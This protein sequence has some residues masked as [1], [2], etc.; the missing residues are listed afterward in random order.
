MH[1]K[2]LLLAEVMA[3]SRLDHLPLAD[4]VHF[5]VSVKAQIV[6]V[7]KD[8]FEAVI[9]SLANAS[10]NAANASNAPAPTNANTRLPSTSSETVSVH[11]STALSSATQEHRYRRIPPTTIVGNGITSLSVA[12]GDP[13]VPCAPT[14]FNT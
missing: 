13:N 3:A 11:R 6:E 5:D 14:T 12:T 7:W 4:G 8:A 1:L 9:A 10:E 2:R